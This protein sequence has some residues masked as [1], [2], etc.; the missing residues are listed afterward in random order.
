MSGPR[1]S[2]IPARAATDKAL[3]PRDLQVLCVLGRHT[4]DLGWCRKSQVKMAEEMGCARS[5]VFEAVERL[6][7]AGYLERHVQEEDSGRDSPHV[8]RVILDPKH[9]DSGVIRAEPDPPELQT[10]V[11]SEGAGT[12]PDP[13]DQPAPPAGI[14]APPA[15]PG[16]APKND[17]LR[18]IER[19]AREDG[20]KI[21]ADG[22]ALLKDWPGFAGMPKDPAMEVWRGLPAEDRAAARR[23][24][25]AW[26]ELLK[27]Q[28][29]SHVP[30]PS[31]YLREK[32]WREA[33]EPEAQKAG[34]PVLAPPFGKLFGAKR[35]QLL[36]T[37][38]PE[39]A[40][41]A[42][43]AFIAAQLADPSENGR[44][45]R[46]ER[47][48]RYGWP[49]VNRMDEIAADARPW[50]LAAFEAQ[51]LEAL[52]SGFEQVRVGG[53]LWLAWQAAFVARGWPWLPDPGRVQ[54]VYFP[55]GGPDALGAFEAALHAS[56]QKQNEGGPDDGGERQAAAE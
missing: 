6:V 50:P 32:L 45:A 15:G 27:R 35:M 5:T 26:L 9:P 41:P 21:E 33:P 53:E 14:S 23:K 29:K 10:A 24:F 40:P 38:Q 12:T 16:P 51:A 49:M 44:R 46:L 18:T 25:P 55:A 2:I 56:G 8:Y 36:A 42:P 19:D 31:T 39:A 37:T 20:K 3:K 4:D 22:W 48:A 43:S 1:L 17:P 28:R 54:W 34:A 47:Q 52:A 7:R 30:A 11:V 13:A